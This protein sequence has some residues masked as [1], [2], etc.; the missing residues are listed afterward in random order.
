MCRQS[1]ISVGQSRVENIKVAYIMKGSVL[2]VHN[3]SPE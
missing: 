1:D 3:I 2:G